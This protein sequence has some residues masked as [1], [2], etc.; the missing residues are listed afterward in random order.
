MTPQRSHLDAALY[1]L[2]AA[3]PLWRHEIESD[4]DLRRHYDELLSR[5]VEQAHPDDRDYVQWQANDLLASR[6]WC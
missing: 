3:L 1:Q 2:H 4:A 5:L 6:G